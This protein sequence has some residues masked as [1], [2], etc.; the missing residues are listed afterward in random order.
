M[1]QYAE[2]WNV[3][4]ICSVEHKHTLDEWNIAKKCSY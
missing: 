3:I 4:Y 2:V 1:T